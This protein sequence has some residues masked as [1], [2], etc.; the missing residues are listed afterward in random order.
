MRGAKKLGVV[1]RDVRGDM[2]PD[3]AKKFVVWHSDMTERVR[4]RDSETGEFEA[5]DPETVDDEA[6]VE[7][8]VPRPTSAPNRVFL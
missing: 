8:P 1:F 6:W 4:A 2:D 5:D 3:I 7:Q